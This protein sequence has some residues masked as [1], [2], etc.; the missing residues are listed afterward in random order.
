ML[1]SRWKA[2]SEINKGGEE[3]VNKTDNKSNFEVKISI[4]NKNHNTKLE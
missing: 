3:V 1:P 2:T 4:M